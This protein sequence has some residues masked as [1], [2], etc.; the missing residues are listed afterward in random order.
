[1]FCGDAIFKFFAPLVISNKR[2]LLCTRE[3]FTLLLKCHRFFRPEEHCWINCCAFGD[4][5]I[6][7]V[8]FCQGAPRS[9]LDIYKTRHKRRLIYRYFCF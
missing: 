3:L 7:C 8:A 9:L 2:F 1:M 6:Q 5:E 4:C